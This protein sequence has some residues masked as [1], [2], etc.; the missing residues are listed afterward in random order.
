[1]PSGWLHVTPH[2]TCSVAVTGLSYASTPGFPR[3]SVSRFPPRP[4]LSP[5]PQK[6]SC[7]AGVTLFRY[8]PP[9][10]LTFTHNQVTGPFPAQRRFTVA[11]LLRPACLPGHQMTDWV[12]EES[13]LPSAPCSRTSPTRG[14]RL[15]RLLVTELACSCHCRE[16]A[17]LASRPC[18][19]QL[20]GLP[21][22]T[23]WVSDTP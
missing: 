23:C 11:Q 16:G 1:M 2:S 7:A 21:S 18:V 12:E 19:L 10:G 13:A 4:A 5:V 6:P 9:V 22:S 3:Y 20:G 17:P 15:Q 8:V 14:M